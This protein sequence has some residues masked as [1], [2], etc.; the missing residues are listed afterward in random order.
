MHPNARFCTVVQCMQL[1]D[2]LPIPTT[3]HA[4]ITTGHNN[5]DECSSWCIANLGFD[6]PQTGTCTCNT[7]CA[8]AAYIK[9]TD[10]LHLLAEAVHSSQ[11][12]NTKQSPQL[13]IKTS[14]LMK[15]S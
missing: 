10:A 14:Q 1:T 6:K 9:I 5:C 11:S 12:S 13:V 3:G 2:M 15:N 7:R 8:V 4:S